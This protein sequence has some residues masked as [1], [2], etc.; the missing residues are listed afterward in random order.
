MLKNILEA[1]DF[2]PAYGEVW[3]TKNVI[4]TFTDK[5]YKQAKNIIL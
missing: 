3:V 4:Y 1:L 2:Q 5:K